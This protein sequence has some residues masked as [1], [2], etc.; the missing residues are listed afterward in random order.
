MQ[1]LIYI[2][3]LNYLMAPKETKSPLPTTV[4]VTG[5]SGYVAS[6]LI[7]QLLAA[8]Y[9]VRSPVAVLREGKK[10]ANG[11]K[12]LGLTPVIASHSSLRI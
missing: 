11:S 5:G 1:L 3:Q 2:T 12:M 7:L 10:S 9:T 8:G 4:L 6:H